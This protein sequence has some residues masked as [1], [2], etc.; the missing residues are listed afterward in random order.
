[1][2]HNTCTFPRREYNHITAYTCTPQINTLR[3]HHNTPRHT[4]IRVLIKSSHPM[5]FQFT[6]P[7]K[8][9]NTFA[10]LNVKA[11]LLRHITKTFLYPHTF[12]HQRTPHGPKYNCTNYKSHASNNLLFSNRKCDPTKHIK[13]FEFLF[14]FIFFYIR[15]HSYNLFSHAYKHAGTSSTEYVSKINHNHTRRTTWPTRAAHACH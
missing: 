8:Q 7:I 1:V 10:Y 6:H 12:Q 3:H 9:H 11:T 14:Y 15:V 2:L 4:H 5:Y 13:T